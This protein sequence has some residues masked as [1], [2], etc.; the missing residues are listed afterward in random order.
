MSSENKVI[1]KAIEYFNMFPLQ[2]GKYYIDNE[3][4]IN[5]TTF[6][7]IKINNDSTVNSVSSFLSKYYTGSNIITYD[8][9]LAYEIALFII[10][11]RTILDKDKISL[12]ITTTKPFNIKVLFYFI[13]TYSFSKVSIIEALSLIN[14]T[15][16]FTLDEQI[17]ERSMRMF[18]S[19]YTKDKISVSI[20]GKVT[21]FN[22]FVTFYLSLGFKPGNFG[23]VLT[24]GAFI[25][26]L[27]NLVANDHQM[28]NDA[29]Q[30]RSEDVKIRFQK[31]LEPQM[32]FEF[33]KV[34][35]GKER[36]I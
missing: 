36:Q 32:G 7:T 21:D 13:D 30:Y 17:K 6:N 12:M 19:K 25:V 8:D 16:I 15:D 27:K 29:L 9:Y 28:Y 34:Y 31:A 18:A 10:K 4:I 5:E 14:M 35:A 20:S 22:K 2:F 3:L 24:G 11:Y 23:A 33:T 26:G 1:K